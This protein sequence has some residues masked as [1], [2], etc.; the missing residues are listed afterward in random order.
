MNN[1]V[2]SEIYKITDCMDDLPYTDIPS[3]IKHLSNPDGFIRQQAHEVL[4]CIG[5]PAIPE[6]IHALQDANL[7]LRW[8]IIKIMES[9]SD[10]ST[11]PALVEQLKNENAGVRWA[12]SNALIGLK[13]ESI[14][15][16]LEALVHDFD[17]IWL[18]QSAHHILH[19]FKDFGKLTDAEVKVFE[20]LEGIEPTASVPWAAQKALESLRYKKR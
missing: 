14:P 7:E 2:I 8:Q 5:G 15:P 12:A 20:A 3:L 13:R 9:I 19:V 10:P 6:L 17:S 4:I 11:I 16:L 1:P 18:R